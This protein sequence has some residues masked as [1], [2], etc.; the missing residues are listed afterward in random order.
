MTLFCGT[1]ARRVVNATRV[2]IHAHGSLFFFFSS[3]SL[4]APS[5]LCQS[6]NLILIRARDSRRVVTVAERKRA[7][8]L[9]ASRAKIPAGTGD[10]SWPISRCVSSR[11][12]SISVASRLRGYFAAS[13]FFSV[14][15]SFLLS[16]LRISRSRSCT[17]A[18]VENNEDT[19]LA[20]QLNPRASI[21]GIAHTRAIPYRERNAETMR[22]TR[23]VSCGPIGA[24]DIARMYRDLFFIPEM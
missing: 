18:R 1:S 23:R 6:V 17:F 2:C 8:G 7:R 15:P 20:V 21:A 5:E 19:R 14:L 9:P 12:R 4:F 10:A 22:A 24:T 13:P 3:R 16:S 11:S